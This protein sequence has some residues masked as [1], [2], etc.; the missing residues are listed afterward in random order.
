M[1]QRIAI[2]GAAGRMG[3]SLI[4]ALA[5]F[6]DARLAGAVVGSGHSQLGV[7]AGELAGIG[8]M[9]VPLTDT[10]P[11]G[12]DC[13]IEFTT[14]AA[15]PQYARWAADCGVC[16]VSGTTGMDSAQHAQ[17]VECAAQTPIL[18]APNMS[19]GVALVMQLVERAARA[20][21]DYD[22]E[23][24]EAH[25]RHKTDAP[26]GTALRLGDAI[27]KGRGVSLDEVA[28]RQR[29]GVDS[30]RKDGEIGFAVTRAGEIIGEHSALFAN[31]SEIIEIRHRAASRLLFARAAVRAAL[32][33][34]AQK[35]GKLYG[36]EDT[37]NA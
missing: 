6:D 20:L 4:A 14:A 10:P 33:L 26:S 32:W 34:C 9:G 29:H 27:A 37:L 7:D 23:V 30:A 31:D 2:A 19:P 21:G 8:K 11:E 36:I 22:A 3:R 16:V 1:A 13:L 35:P 5:E 24:H 25:H 28:S 18:W 17:L 12:V 15:A